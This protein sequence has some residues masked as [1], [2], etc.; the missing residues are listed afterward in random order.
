MNWWLSDERQRFFCPR[1]QR[2][3]KNCLCACILQPI[4]NKI[5]ETTHFLV[6]ILRIVFSFFQIIM[7]WKH[8]NWFANQFFFLEKDRKG[9]IRANGKWTKK[10]KN[11]SSSSN[12]NYNDN[13]SKSKTNEANEKS[14]WKGNKSIAKQSAPLQKWRV[15]VCIAVASY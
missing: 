3:E 8:R 10:Q 4:K 15:C 6:S 14:K 12:N 11:C 7:F 9:N 13:N 1:L 5:T 2:R